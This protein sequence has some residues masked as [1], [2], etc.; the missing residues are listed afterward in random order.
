MFKLTAFVLYNCEPCTKSSGGTR[1]RLTLTRRE[2]P[3]LVPRY[4]RYCT[5][6]CKCKLSDIRDTL[7]FAEHSS[8]E[9]NEDHLENT[10]YA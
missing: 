8:E 6:R 7:I 2:G 1:A 10:K 3:C 9:G 5:C 4:I